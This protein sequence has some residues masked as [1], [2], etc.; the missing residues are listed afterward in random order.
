[1]LKRSYRTQESL[2]RYW[3][4]QAV[5]LCDSID[6]STLAEPIEP[7]VQA[8]E[9]LR[10]PRRVVFIGGA[11]CGKSSL[12]GHVMGSSVPAGVAMADTH[13]RWRFRW[14]IWRGWNWSIR[15]IVA[16]QR[17]RIPCAGC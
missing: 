11:R 10:R 3:A 9:G 14:S 4:Q 2:V 13:I 17:C 5:E 7:V 8:V 6:D 16:G 12:L 1:M 15:P